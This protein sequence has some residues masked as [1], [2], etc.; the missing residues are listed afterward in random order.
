MTEKKQRNL[1]PGPSTKKIRAMMNL[2][3]E[4]GVTRYKDLEVEIEMPINY[5]Q[6]QASTSFDFSSYDN[7]EQKEKPTLEERD[8]LGFTE[9]DYL[10]RSAE[11]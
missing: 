7:N 10:W 11:A 1:G 3:S 4:F 2:M 8:D 6:P 9:E 5:A